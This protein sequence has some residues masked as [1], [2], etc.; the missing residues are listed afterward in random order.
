[1]GYDH[2]YTEVQGQVCHFQGSHV[3]VII[4]EW[5]TGYFVSHPHLKDKAECVSYLRQEKTS[6]IMTEC[7]EINIINILIT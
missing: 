4:P 1:M 6:H 5:T 3:T 7:I 2:N